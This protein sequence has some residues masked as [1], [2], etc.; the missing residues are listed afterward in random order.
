MKFHSNI[1]FGEVENRKALYYKTLFTEEKHEAELSL[2]LV[3]I[4]QWQQEIRSIAMMMS[5]MMLLSSK[6]LQ[7]Q[8][9]IKS[10]SKNF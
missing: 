10:S 3:V 1:M 7:R 5:Q 2:S 9:F 4:Q 6:M 8:L